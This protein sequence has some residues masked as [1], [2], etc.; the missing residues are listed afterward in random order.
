L[1]GHAHHAAAGEKPRPSIASE[2]DTSHTNVSFTVEDFFAPV[3]EVSHSQIIERVKLYDVNGL[4]GR[5]HRSPI[6]GQVYLKEVE[7]WRDFHLVDLWTR[8]KL[9]AL[10]NEH[11]ADT[12]LYKPRPLQMRTW[13]YHCKFRKAFEQFQIG[14]NTEAFLFEALHMR[15]VDI[16]ISAGLWSPAMVYAPLVPFT[17]LTD[18]SGVFIFAAIVF[19]IVLVVS[20]AT[21]HNRFYFWTRPMTVLARLIFLVFVCTRIQGGALQLLGYLA[22]VFAVLG[23][24]IRG[25]FAVLSNMQCYCHY[26]IIRT[27]PNQ[28]FVCWRVGDHSV[29]QKEGER[30]LIPEGVTGIQDPGDGTLCL[31][32]NIQGLLMELIPMDKDADATMFNEEHNIRTS[33]P[34][35]GRLTYF[36]VDL[37]SPATK[38]VS[39]LDLMRQMSRTPTPKKPGSSSLGAG[40]K[41]LGH[42]D[43]QKHQTHKPP[44]SSGPRGRQSSDLT[45]EDA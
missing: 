26:E 41:A 14:L 10:P 25:D 11:A 23:D 20:V 7:S 33:E 29:M 34:S 12:S 36:G 19:L 3:F 40:Y 5:S 16:P 27:L 45:V 39:E 15:C 22:T 13:I 17:L 42:L 32:A 8:K 30:A 9:V 38:N 2:G 37:F 31:I 4:V 24:L 43:D 6:T 35:L 28:I 44:N 21:N 1:D 18:D